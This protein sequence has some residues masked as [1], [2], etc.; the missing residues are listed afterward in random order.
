MGSRISFY[1]TLAFGLFI[2]N[3]CFANSAASQNSTFNRLS[4]NI[5]GGYNFGDRGPSS[6]LPLLESN[7]NRN[8]KA[9]PTFTGGIQYAISP[10]WSVEAGYQ[11]AS[12]Q[13]QVSDFKT[14]VN[15][16]VFKNII[17]LS[18][19]LSFDRVSGVINPFLSGGF[20]IDRYSF[21]S[22][23]ASIDDYS[24]SFTLGGGLAVKASQHIDVITHYEYQ[25]ANNRFDNRSTGFEADL[26]TSLSVGIRFNLG[27]SNSNPHPSRQ[28]TPEEDPTLNY[29]RVTAKLKEMD[30]LNKKV[31]KLENRRQSEQVASNTK[32]INNL[33]QRM[34]EV[35]TLLKKMRSKINKS[36]DRAITDSSNDDNKK[37][38]L[39]IYVQVFATHNLSSAKKIRSQTVEFLDGR[40]DN[41]EDQIFVTKRG[42]FYQVLI[43]E[44]REPERALRVRQVMSNRHSDAFTITFPRPLN[45]QDLYDDLERVR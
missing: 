35:E 17:H 25:L 7:F 26:L 11:Y 16:I 37:I 32:A 30:E 41:T 28:S 2:F 38:P 21:S 8:T 19:I 14:T 23:T 33:A 31:S 10:T 5:T 24:T 34:D 13:G 42:Q 6:G 44:F 1:L 40:L 22:P 9:T 12:V 45:L 3:L 18:R 29:Q 36:P 39:G 4:I 20:A 43:G 15:S 27:T